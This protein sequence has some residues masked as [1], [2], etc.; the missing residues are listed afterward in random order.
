MVKALAQRV[1]IWHND[2]KEGTL[3]VARR[4]ISILEGA[5]ARAVVADRLAAAL[6]MGHL[7]GSFEG[8]AFLCVL[9]GDGT[10]LTAVDTALAVLKESLTEMQEYF[11]K[12]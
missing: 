6:G 11:D 2:S 1:G 4:L 3:Q 7:A 5:G 10:L 12:Q 8:C 9:G